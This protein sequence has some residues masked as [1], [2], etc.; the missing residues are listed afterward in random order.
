MSAGI[1]VMLQAVAV[2]VGATALMDLWNAALKLA[3][4]IPSLSFCLLG[5]WIRHFPEGRFRHASLVTAARKPLECATGWIAHYSIG[6][7]F[8]LVFVALASGEWLS[9]P[10]LLPAL[11]WGAVTVA[12]PYLVL[13]PAFGLGVA[14][15][16]TPD[17][18]RVRLK[19]LATHVV[20]GV[21]LYLTALGAALLG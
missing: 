14:A 16:K 20:F 10:T 5:R 4:G 8:A 3:L 15:S 18:T 13:Q 2:G 9:R 12:A 21:G 1:A 7:G 17:P 6:V 19:S 11:A